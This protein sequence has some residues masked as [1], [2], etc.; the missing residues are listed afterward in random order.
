MAAYGVLNFLTCFGE[1]GKQGMNESSMAHTLHGKKVAERAKYMAVEALRL[2][3]KG[4]IFFRRKHVGWVGHHCPRE[5][6]R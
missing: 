5:V 1:F 2:V 3:K 4:N 6:S